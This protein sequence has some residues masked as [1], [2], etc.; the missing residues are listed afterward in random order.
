MFATEAQDEERTQ[1]LVR[2]LAGAWKFPCD[3]TVIAAVGLRRVAAALERAHQP[4]RRAID[5]VSVGE[6]FPDAFALARKL[7]LPA[8]WLTSAVAAAA[9]DPARAP[10]GT[11]TVE[12]VEPIAKKAAFC[13]PRSASSAS[14]TGRGRAPAARR[15]RGPSS[16]PVRGV[17]RRDFAG[18]AAA[19]EVAGAGRAAGPARRSAVRA[20]HADVF[21]S[22]PTA[23]S[24]SGSSRPHRGRRNARLFHVKQ[25]AGGA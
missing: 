13:G 17:R 2:A 14:A 8:R 3:V 15:S 24:T 10:P 12:L 11:L 23:P 21:P 25:S 7:D 16:G 6:D 1:E 18:D 5:R 4:D 22:S 9:R 20:H 19:A